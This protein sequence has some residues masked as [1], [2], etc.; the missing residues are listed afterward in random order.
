MPRRENSCQ[1]TVSTPGSG[2]LSRLLKQRRSLHHVKWNSPNHMKRKD[3]GWRAS[4]EE[5]CA[6]TSL[7]CCDKRAV[8]PC[9]CQPTQGPSKDEG[10]NP[11]PS[12]ARRSGDR[13]RCFFLVCSPLVCVCLSSWVVRAVC[14]R[15]VLRPLPCLLLFSGCFFPCGRRPEDTGHDLAS[16]PGRRRCVA[17]S[18]H[19]LHLSYSCDC[20]ASFVEISLS[21]SAI[22]SMSVAAEQ[23]GQVPGCL[24]W[25]T[26]STHLT[27]EK[28][29]TSYRPTFY[30]NLK[31]R[32]K[33]NFVTEKKPF[34]K[35]FLLLK[36][37]TR[38]KAKCLFYSH[39]V[40]F[41]S[42]RCPQVVFYLR[43]RF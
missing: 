7:D 26:S 17:F 29:W 35:T 43:P 9:V 14:V 30:E 22:L 8:V 36:I 38:G 32:F 20:G 2:G 25:W 15:R 28:L 21:E 23:Y 6:L 27:V 40:K 16:I 4:K 41:Q 10:P 34:S 13:R 18:S 19:S 12:N 37:Y 5:S 3:W 42:R 24:L 31:I 39:D 11:L 1:L 33:D